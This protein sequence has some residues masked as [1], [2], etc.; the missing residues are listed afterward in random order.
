M[1]HLTYKK[2]DKKMIEVNDMT[3]EKEVMASSKYGKPVIVIAYAAWCP[4][5]K[6]M[7]NYAVPRLEKIYSGKIKFVKIAIQMQLGQDENPKIK[8]KYSISRYPTILLFRNE[9]MIN[10]KISEDL[11]MIQFLDI[12]ELADLAINKFLG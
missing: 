6:S 7:L 11:E 1:V 3:F 4:H 2:E 12:Q 8:T 10:K 9:R 5:S